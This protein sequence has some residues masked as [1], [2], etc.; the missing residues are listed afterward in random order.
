MLLE[1]HYESPG[2]ST[3]AGKPAAN[4]SLVLRT[5]YTWLENIT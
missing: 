3:K 4:S 5:G 1:L 2:L